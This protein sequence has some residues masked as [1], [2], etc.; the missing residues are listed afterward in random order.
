MSYMFYKAASFN[1]P[2]DSWNTEKVT[3]MKFMFFDAKSFNQPLNNWDIRKVKCMTSMF[4]GPRRLTSACS[5]K[6]L[7]NGPLWRRS[8][9][10]INSGGCLLN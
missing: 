8:T 4:H 7:A 1:Q 9:L 10:E 5:L 2:I 3:D 6:N